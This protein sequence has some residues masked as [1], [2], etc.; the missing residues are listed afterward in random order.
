GLARRASPVNARHDQ[1]GAEVL[2]R[3]QLACDP[4]GREARPHGGGGQREGPRAAGGLA[5]E[6]QGAQVG[7]HGGLEPTQARAQLRGGLPAGGL[8]RASVALVLER[9]LDP[10]P[11]RGAEPEAEA[12][13]GA[14]PGLG[15]AGA[16]E[17]A[18]PGHGHR[19][20]SEQVVGHGLAHVARQL[21]A[22]AGGDHEHQ[23]HALRAAVEGEGLAGEEQ[24]PQ[25]RLGEL[26]REGQEER[27]RARLP[28]A[29]A[30]EGLVQPRRL[31]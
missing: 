28:A 8:G 12:L 20:Q 9:E 16:A 26:E 31:P 30:A 3:W 5:E 23:L 19:G 4:E 18:Q 10:A 1:A 29:R 14:D 7:Q 6:R 15:L 13:L 25:Q 27:V 22:A 21:A 24:A 11:T 2:R 17:E